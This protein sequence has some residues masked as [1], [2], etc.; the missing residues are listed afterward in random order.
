[1]RLLMSP[2]GA[3]R[4]VLVAAIATTVAVGCGSSPAASP[5]QGEGALKTQS[6]TVTP[7][8]EIEVRHGMELRLVAGA[9]L[10]L[11]IT[12]QANLL[13][14]VTVSQSGETLVLDATRDYA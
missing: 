8:T 12:A 11:E 2:I 9:P 1:M 14:L 3:A 10:S 7:F 6:R 4:L 5:L 13:D